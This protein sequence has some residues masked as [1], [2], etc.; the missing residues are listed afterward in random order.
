MNM[1]DHA[2]SFSASC[3]QADAASSAEAI[4]I[5]LLKS[6]KRPCSDLDVKVADIVAVKVEQSSGCIQCNLRTSPIPMRP[7]AC[8]VVCQSAQ[9]VACSSHRSR[10][11]EINGVVKAHGCVSWPRCISQGM[12]KASSQICTEDLTSRGGWGTLAVL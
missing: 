10:D 8:A 12:A 1:T 6:H 2:P 11:P 4:D 7:P 5:M 3:C 9:Q